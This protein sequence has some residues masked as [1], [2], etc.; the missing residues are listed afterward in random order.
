MRRALATSGLE[1]GSKDG[2]RR[3]PGQQRRLVQLEL[4]RVLVEVHARGHLDAVRPVPEVD[5]V[6]VRGEDPVLRPALLELP[7]ERGLLELA[8]D[9]ALLL[10]V[11][12]LDE[13]LRDGRA[14]LHDRLRADVGP[15]RAGHAPDVDALVLPEA[16]VLHG[17]DRLLHDGR[18]LLRIDDDAALRAP[19]HRQHGFPVGRVDVAEAL[20]AALVAG[21]ELRE[22]AGD[23]A[24]E[25]ERERHRRDEA[26]D[27]DESE[28][29]ELADPAATLSHA[30]LTPSEEHEGR[31][32][33]TAG[34][35]GAT[36]PAR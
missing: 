31:S 10:R 22:L 28:K 11:L 18:D 34:S 9:R 14:A 36:R 29:S 17:D 20:G 8:A 26:D 1:A 3:Q 2:V 24:H 25:A 21:L 30:A 32:L 33:A 4:V 6:Q 23:R 19:Q 7:G 13:L 16:P 12:V 35:S 15:D 5:R 27:G